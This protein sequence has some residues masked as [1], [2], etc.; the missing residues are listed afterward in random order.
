MTQVVSKVGIHCIGPKRNGYGAFLRTINAAGRSL[1]VVKCRDDFGA[2]D[3]PLALWPDVL[4]IGAVT[5]WDD[6]GYNADEAYNRIVEMARKNPKIKYWE[7][8]NERNG[9]YK[10]QAD[11]YIVLMPR[12]AA[13]GLRL[14]MFNCATGTPQ[15]PTIDDEGYREIKRACKVARDG[16][17]DVLLGLHEYEPAPDMIGRYKVLAKYL[18]DYRALIPIVITEYGYETYPQSATFLNMIRNNDPLYMADERVLGC[19]TWTLG[20]G[21]WQGSNF[22]KDLEALGEYISSVEGVT[23]VVPPIY[24]DVSESGMFTA[25]EGW[26][27]DEGGAVWSLSMPRN[28]DAGWTVLRNGVQ[29]AGGYAEALLYFN[30]AMYATNSNAEWYKATAN[31]WQ[32]IAGDPR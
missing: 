10:Q 28:S 3:E 2:I 19:A 30:G 20:G 11:L 31:S 14:C 21:G 9:D 15:Y 26:L 6:A 18:E 29:H 17:Y 8:F 7:Y 5:A 25:Y 27:I 22:E 24:S 32:K 1:S 13:V 23:D 4:T 16:G 12:L